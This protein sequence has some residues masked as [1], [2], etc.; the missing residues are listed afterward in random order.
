M[1]GKSRS[2]VFVACSIAAWSCAPPPDEDHAAAVR[3]AIEPGTGAPDVLINFANEPA[4][5]V[6]PTNPNNIV[7]PTTASASMTPT[8]SS[9]SR[10]TGA[11]PGRRRSG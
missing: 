7:F 6:N 10:P 3:Q 8:R 2:I 9:P 5:A 1:S 11:R 4:I